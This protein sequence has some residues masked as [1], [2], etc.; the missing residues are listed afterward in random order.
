MDSNYRKNNILKPIPPVNPIT[1]LREE[2]KI[3][4]DMSDIEKMAYKAVIHQSIFVRGLAR[5]LNGGQESIHTEKLIKE[6]IM[7]KLDEL[8]NLL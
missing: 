5:V 2:N 7:K 6:E 3:T 1:F 8:K 4:V